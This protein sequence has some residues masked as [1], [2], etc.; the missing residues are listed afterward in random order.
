MKTKLITLF[1]LLFV[2]ISAGAQSIIGTWWSSEDDMDFKFAFNSDGSG[3]VAMA[4]EDVE[5]FDDSDVKL[6]INFISSVPV[7]WQKEG[8]MLFIERNGEGSSNV[9]YDVICDDAAARALVMQYVKSQMAELKQVLTESLKQVFEDNLMSISIVKLTD[10]ELTLSI[11]DE[12]LTFTHNKMTPHQPEPSG[13]VVSEI[14]GFEASDLRGNTMSDQRYTAP[15]T[16]GDEHVYI[17][18]EQSAQFPGGDAGL[19]NYIATHMRYP[20]SAQEQEIQGVVVL[21][22]VV[23]TDGKVGK[24]EV[25]K[26]LHNRNEPESKSEWLKEHKGATGKDYKRYVKKVEENNRLGIDTCDGEAVRV[27][28]SLP[29][30]VPAKLDGKVVPSWVM[31]PLRFQLQ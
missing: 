5:D 25:V 6:K 12:E 20:V 10:D 11:D 15:A 8:N 18:V 24:V 19:L 13:V 22:F 23:D 4:G 16:S 29:R 7:K 17:D 26:S 31:L 1:M 21:R 30:F 2:S 9:D 28:K 27:V 3:E 14:A